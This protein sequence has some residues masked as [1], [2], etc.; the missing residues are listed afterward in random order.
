MPKRRALEEPGI[1]E[2]DPNYHDVG[3]MNCSNPE[4]HEAH[5]ALN[6]ECPWGC[7]SFDKEKWL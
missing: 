2:P 1:A 6:G 4:G 3:A 5:M 7:G